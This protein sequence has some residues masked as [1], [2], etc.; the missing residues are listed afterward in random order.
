M[1]QIT[2]KYKLRVDWDGSTG[3]AQTGAELT[4]RLL[5]LATMRGRDYASNLIGKSVAGSLTGEL[6]NTSGDYSSFK[7]GSPL[8]GY[9]GPDKE[10]VLRGHG[11]AAQFTIANSEYFTG[12]DVLDVTTGDFSLFGWVY[13]DSLSTAQGIVNKR[14]R[15]SSTNLGFAVELQTDGTLDFLISDGT[16][17]T[18]ISS[19]TVFSTGIFYFWVLTADRSGNGQ[20]YINNGAAEGAASIVSQNGTLA[21]AINFQVGAGYSSSAN[22]FFGGRMVSVGHTGKLLSSAERTFLYRDGDGV[23]YRD[24]GLTGD[25]SALK[26][27]LNAWYDLQETSGN[28]ADSENSNTLT[29]T[30]TVTDAE[31]IANYSLWRGFTR[32]IEPKPN[33]SGRNTA[34]VKATGPIGQVNLNKISLA[35]AS[36]ELTGT[37]WDRILT[38]AGWPANQR[39]TDAGR[40]TM[41]RY[42]V[43]NEVK[44]LTALRQVEITETGYGGESP[45]GRLVFEDRRHRQ[46]PPFNTSQAIF[47]DA[48]GGALRYSSIRQLDSQAQ[49]FHIFT[50]AVV[51]DTVG[52][53]ATLW[54]L[55][56][57][58]SNSPS[59]PPGES[60]TFW[61]EFPNPNDGND[62]IGVDA[63]T[64]LVENTD[65]EANSQ[66]GGGGT[67]LST[68][69]TVVLSKFWQSMKIVITN[70]ATVP[71]FITL[72]QAR[73]TPVT[74]DDPSRVTVETSVTDPRTFP[75][76]PQFIPNIGEAFDWAYWHDNVFSTVQPI[77][78]MR[79]LGNRDQAHLAQ[80]FGR[81]ISD[82]ITVI[83][84]N[85]AGLGINE[86][87]YIEYI[88]MEM[89]AV[90]NTVWV[91][92]GLSAAKNQ[93]AWTLGTSKLGTETRLALT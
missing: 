91:T 58:G 26:T 13:I 34:G 1:A 33:I 87:F 78:E 66:A 88:R 52:S 29:D 92:W 74:R 8:A 61:A 54:T 30:N 17:V 75:N 89:D 22:R 65:Y 31:G 44:T 77:L 19:T 43:D 16:A 83:G 85:D 64:T 42:Y 25:G 41:N 40:T 23:R 21:N 48:L 28:R 84:T 45:D 4:S 14:D 62:A 90:R 80:S 39:T 35:S 86:D 57:S 63:W 2:P 56:S 71:A 47:T 70:G 53:L 46:L 9:V 20:F 68:N 93:D 69:L 32:E 51:T 15:A 76:P 11:R 27:S 81:D 36:S 55:T 59:I 38:E 10:I 12:G 67:D 60:R 49:L 50:L 37:A 72:L 79:F 6:L 73:G 5:A 3:F 7:T 82:R 24:I 18:T